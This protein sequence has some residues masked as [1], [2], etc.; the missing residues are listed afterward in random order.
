MLTFPDHGISI[1]EL[2]NDDRADFGIF[3]RGADVDALLGTVALLALEEL[4]DR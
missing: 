1:S 2:V 3:P 4:S